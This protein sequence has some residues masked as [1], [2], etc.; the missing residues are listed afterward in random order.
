MFKLLKMLEG[1]QVSASSL[2]EVQAIASG[3]R[4]LAPLRHAID[5]FHIA[6]FLSLPQLA[7]S[8]CVIPALLF[9]M[10]TNSHLIAYVCQNL[11]SIYILPLIKT[12]S[13]VR[14]F[15]ICN[16]KAFGG[17]FLYFL[18]GEKAESDSR[19]WSAAHVGINL[20]LKQIFFSHRCLAHNSEGWW[21]IATL[22]I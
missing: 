17:F 13:L 8:K 20:L 2:S 11:R 7:H 14:F 21:K 3:Q 19:F 15:T 9:D 5:I 1:C 16:H 18:L 12:V 22:P 4:H 6:Q 10:A